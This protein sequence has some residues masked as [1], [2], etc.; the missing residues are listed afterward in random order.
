[1]KWQGLKSPIITPEEEENTRRLQ[2]FFK[3]VTQITEDPKWQVEVDAFIKEK[4]NASMVSQSR[5]GSRSSP[6]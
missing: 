2:E 1:M 3:W 5:S 4:Y 6:A